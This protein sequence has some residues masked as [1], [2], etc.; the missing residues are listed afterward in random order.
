MITPAFLAQRCFQM[1]AKYHTSECP[2]HSFNKHLLSASAVLGTVPNVENKTI[3]GWAH[4]AN[5]LVRL[6]EEA[7]HLPRR[8]NRY[9]PHLPMVRLLTFLSITSPS[10][11]LS[12]AFPQN[13]VTLGVLWWPTFWGYLKDLVDH[14]S[15]RYLV[16]LPP[17]LASN[18]VYVEPSRHKHN[19]TKIN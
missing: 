11:F 13:T 17:W 12:S 1:S 3:K 15:V 16:E 2:I 5:I 10:D 7:Y 9:L 4:E 8:N 14:C 18:L 19:I 6:L